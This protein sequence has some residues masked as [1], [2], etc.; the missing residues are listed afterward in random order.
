MYQPEDD[1]NFEESLKRL[2]NNQRDRDNQRDNYQENEGVSAENV[3]IRQ[4][5]IEKIFLKLIAFGL[6]IGLILSLVVFI[7]LNKL[8]LSKKPYEIEQEKQQIDNSIEKIY[9]LNNDSIYRKNET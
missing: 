9:Q 5:Q 7:L 2:Q 8:G 6:G 3:K 4:Q 1:F